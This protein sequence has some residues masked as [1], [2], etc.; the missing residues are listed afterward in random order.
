MKLKELI[1]LIGEKKLKKSLGQNLLINDRVA[2]E[3]VEYLE[4]DDEEVLEI[5]PGTGIVTQKLIEKGLKPV[6]V[7]IDSDFCRVLKERFNDRIYLFCMDFFK[8]PPQDFKGRLITGSL[9]YRGAKKMVA[10][11]LLNFP[12]FT[13][14][15]FLLQREVADILM[16]EPKTRDYSPITVITRIRGRVKKIRDVLPASFYPEPRVVS[17]LVLFE[18]GKAPPSSLFYTFLRLA[19][20]SRRKNLR[21]N[22]KP[23]IK[24]LPEWFPSKKRAEEIYPEEF[25]EIFYRLKNEGFLSAISET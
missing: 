11:I 10:H 17:S 18:M 5:G 1:E 3:M 2:K 16:A 21:N 15:T 7:E 22:L 23:V 12:H 19:F 14:G 4:G 25:L 9:P 6:C 8:F 24:S 13:R 20:S